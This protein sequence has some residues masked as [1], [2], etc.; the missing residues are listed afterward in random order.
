M[1][2]FCLLYFICHFSLCP[3]SIEYLYSIS[4][5]FDDTYLYS[6]GDKGDIPRHFRLY[7]LK[8]NSWK[9]SILHFSEIKQF[10]VTNIYLGCFKAPYFFIW[11]FYWTFCKLKVTWSLKLDFQWCI[12]SYIRWNFVW[13]TDR[14]N[15][16]SCQVFLYANQR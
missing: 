10:W 4:I 14:I 7:T 16:Y 6:N 11:C 2:I 12:I 8:L 15:L 1:F 9:K 3:L 13:S 5:F